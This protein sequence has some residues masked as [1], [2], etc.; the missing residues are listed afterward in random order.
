MKKYLSIS[1]LA[2]VSLLAIQGYGQG[3]E[4]NN[5][6]AKFGQV[7]FYINNYYLDSIDNNDVTEHAVKSMISALDPHSSYISADEV[8]AMNE[9]LEGNFEGVGIEFA[10]IRDTLTVASPISGG[11]SESVGIRAGD[12]I[13]VIDGEDVASIGITN[14]MVFKYLR[15]PKGSKVTLEIVRRGVEGNLVFE[16][17]R[18]KIPINS[19]DAAYEVSPGVVYVR[20]S[21][22]AANSSREILS[23]ILDLNMAQ[24]DGFILDLRGNSGGYLGTAMEITNFFLDAGQTIVYTEGMKVPKMTEKA[25]GTGFYKNGPLVVLVD[26]NSASASE[27]VAGAVQDWDRGM[28]IGR[29]TFG[30]GL[31]QQMLPLNDGAQLRLTVARYHTPSGR[32]IQAP[33]REGSKEDYY[34]AFFE[35]YQRGELFS[36][37]SIQLP[38]SLKYKTLKKGRTV[39]GGGGIMPDIFVPADTTYQTDYY[40]QL[41]RKGVILDFMNDYSDKNRSRLK[42]AYP[43]FDNFRQGFSFGE[44]LFE[45]FKSLA[46]SRGIS[47]DHEEFEQSFPEIENYMKALLARSIYGTPA[48]YKI[49]NSYNDKVFE[50]AMDYINDNR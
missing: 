16:V 42:S 22:F 13:V 7:L 40:S 6:I 4:L 41:L 35:R 36:R 37:D 50:A 20:L 18:D 1:I 44:D 19:V 29:R 32:V 2:V 31:V 30:K 23:A 15:G 46:E 25:K 26:E 3:K 10:I 17:I 43:E 14:D 28:I 21:R 39:Y 33:Y 34:K 38:D 11:P 47:Y 48:F 9:P 49:V 12:K 45:S 27:I 5:H 24:I 8:K